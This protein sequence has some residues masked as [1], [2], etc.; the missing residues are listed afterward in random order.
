MSPQYLPVSSHFSSFC[1][2]WLQIPT[3]IPITSV[4][5]LCPQATR[6]Q[7]F[8]GTNAWQPE[9]GDK[10]PSCLSLWQ[11]IAAVWACESPTES[12]V[13]PGDTKPQGFCSNSWGGSS[14][15]YLL[16]TRADVTQ[17]TTGA[18]LRPHGGSRVGSWAWWHYLT[19]WIKLVGGGAYFS[20]LMSHPWK[21]TPFNAAFLVSLR[22]QTL[23][24][25]RNSSDGF[26]GKNKWGMTAH[27]LLLPQEGK[28]ETKPHC[29]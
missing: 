25:R 18:I 19:S 12:L 27:I 20:L 23:P 17:W 29:G 13:F 5:L 9:S 1:A 22:P 28:Q 2:H 4:C 14:L 6:S 24:S 8:Q 10:R 26:I 7:R 11:P 16:W 3:P 21:G 15:P